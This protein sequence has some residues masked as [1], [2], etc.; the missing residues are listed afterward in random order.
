M[1]RSLASSRRLGG[2]DREHKLV[3]AP[4]QFGKAPASSRAASGTRRPSLALIGQ[5]HA[6]RRCATARGAQRLEQFTRE[7]LRSVP[8]FGTDDIRR[9]RVERPPGKFVEA[10]DVSDGELEVRDIRIAIGL[11]R[12]SCR[13]RLIASAAARSTPLRSVR[14]TAWS[15]TRSRCGAA[16][17]TPG[18]LQRSV[19]DRCPQ[20]GLPQHK[21]KLEG[22]K[23]PSSSTTPTAD[24]PVLTDD[25]R[26]E[27]LRLLAERLRSPN[28][29]DR[30][31]LKRIE[32]LTGDEE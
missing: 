2:V 6:E 19:R 8:A 31:T 3:I 32:Q 22:V 12:P 21:D 28:G 13:S 11:R 5:R 24:A 29:L 25:Q 20:V 23:R 4:E 27:R 26:T 14:Q 1:R 30:E 17:S 9:H 15:V 18:A 16:K 7:P 10:F